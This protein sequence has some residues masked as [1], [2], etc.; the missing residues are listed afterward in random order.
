MAFGDR[1]KFGS[2]GAEEIIRNNTHFKSGRSQ[3][4]RVEDCEH[5][6]MFDQPFELVRL[7]IGFFEGKVKGKFQPKSRHEQ[8][9]PANYKKFEKVNKFPWMK[10]LAV[11]FVLVFFFI[12]VCLP[13]LH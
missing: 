9:I 11:V 10:I 6:M 2:D 3:L 7:M 13:Y 4:F 12:Q 5:P 1:D 8:V